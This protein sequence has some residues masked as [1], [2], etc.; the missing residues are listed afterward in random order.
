MEFD[1]D[2][3]PCRYRG[4]PKKN[5]AEGVNDENFVYLS[6]D[7]VYLRIFTRGGEQ[8]ARRIAA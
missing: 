8:V 1:P 5:P 7:Y 4:G 6:D 2:A 3:L